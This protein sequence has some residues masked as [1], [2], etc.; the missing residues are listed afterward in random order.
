MDTDIAVIEEAWAFE[1]AYT[2]G[3]EEFDPI[4]SA[5][6]DEPVDLSHFTD[7]ARYCSGIAPTLRCIA[8]YADRGHGTFTE[9]RQVAVIPPGFEGD[10]P[11]AAATVEASRVFGPVYEQWRVGAYDALDG[12]G[13]SFDHRTGSRFV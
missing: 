6:S 3:F 13:Y 10:M 11:T 1:E 4:P 7:T 12:S 2:M 5:E 9:D 8:G